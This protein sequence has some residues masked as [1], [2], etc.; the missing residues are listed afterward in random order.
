ML[1]GDKSKAESDAE[2]Q[3]EVAKKRSEAIAAAQE[4]RER[5]REESLAAEAELRRL[6]ELDTARDTAAEQEAARR[7]AEVA[8]AQEKLEDVQKA[9]LRLLR[10]REAAMQ[11]LRRL[12]ALGE[13]IMKK[14]KLEAGWK[15][16]GKSV[17]RDVVI[18]RRGKEVWV[19]DDDED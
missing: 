14:P 8:A 4:R 10:K 1:R 13:E 16:K 15:G 5:A 11:D 2:A 17:N 9:E 6:E 7:Q 19:L 18:D 12:G 3:A